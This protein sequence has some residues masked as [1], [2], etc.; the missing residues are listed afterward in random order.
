M[1]AGYLLNELPRYVL[2]SLAVRLGLN[3]AIVLQ[4]LHWCMNRESAL[5]EGNVRW[6]KVPM[7]EWLRHLPFWSE[8]T[9]R[10]TLSSL[11]DSELIETRRGKEQGVYAIHYD[12]LAVRLTDEAGHSD[13]V[14]GQGDSPLYRGEIE[15]DSRK[16]T[17]S[18]G[19]AAAATLPGMEP[20]PSES[21]PSLDDVA[22]DIFKLWQDICD[23][24]DA[25]FSEARLKAG[26]KAAR[27]SRDLDEWRRIIKGFRIYRERKAERD[28]KK[29]G[30]EFTHLVATH[31]GSGD[32]RSRMEFFKEQD[33]GTVHHDSVP[34]L[35]H[36]RIT[37][38]QVQ[39]VEMF[40]QPD[41]R[42]V[43]ER[44]EEAQRWLQE[45][46]GLVPVYDEQDGRVTWERVTT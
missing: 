31:P 10:R 27:E 12:R 39:V 21:E 43:R 5:V 36:E 26:R 46:A 18:D 34:S 37:R 3:E 15:R 32:V 7:D 6:V 45:N 23:K 30:L 24:Q 11:R 41:S 16:E 2:P 28:G 17:T 33:D 38:R 8:S 35:L 29:P 19:D 14:A 20:P 25:D 9:I 4:Q 40:Q 1:R 13:A 42:A 44:G 22:E